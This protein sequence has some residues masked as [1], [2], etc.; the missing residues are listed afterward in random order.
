MI[1]MQ[2]VKRDFVIACEIPKLI[3]NLLKN[4][5]LKQKE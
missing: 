4:P 3:Y 5:K 2:R 1:R